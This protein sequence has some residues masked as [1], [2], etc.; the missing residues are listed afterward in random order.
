MTV[1][2][3]LQ[4]EGKL[5]GL[6]PVSWDFGNHQRVFWEKESALRSYEDDVVLW[7]AAKAM[8]MDEIEHPR[9]RRPRDIRD[10]LPQ[11]QQHLAL[12]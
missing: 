1:A 9:R 11:Q 2:L 7:R 8:R 3:R 5:R 4:H 6:V 10:F 12:G